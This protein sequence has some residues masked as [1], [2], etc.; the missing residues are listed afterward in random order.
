M[1]PRRDALAPTMPKLPDD[2]EKVRMSFAEHL[3]ELR[4]RVVRSLLLIAV[5]FITGFAFGR[6]VGAIFLFPY[7]C[8]CAR[9]AADE[10]LTEKLGAQGITEGIFF[11]VKSSLI[12]ALL[13]GLPYL[14]YQLWSFVAV[15]LYPRERKVV[16]RYLPG[17]LGLGIAGVLFGYFYLVPMVMEVLMRMN[18]AAEFRPLYTVELYFSLF[19][20]LTV[21][22]AVVFQ[23]PLILA[24][25]GA[26]GIVDAKVLR[27]YRRHFILFAFVLGAFLTPPDPYSQIALAVPTIAL[28]EVGI[29]LVAWKGKKAAPPAEGP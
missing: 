8:A 26:A 14:L 10:I 16:L 5:L 4:S 20:M 1:V 24:G 3:E 25:L 7:E 2:P 29:L 15:G 6:T 9:L 19:L 21:A 18:D 13:V 28:Y 27:R 17:A 11:T 22:L 12:V 23:L